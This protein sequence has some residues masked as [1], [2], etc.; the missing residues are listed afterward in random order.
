MTPRLRRR[1]LWGLVVL[2]AFIPTACRRLGPTDPSP[3]DVTL[4]VVSGAGQF[5]PPSE[6]LIDSLAVSVRAEDGDLPVEGIL[7]EWEI[8]AGPVGAQLTPQ[9]SQSDSAGLARARLRLGSDLGQYLI[10]ASIRDRPE[11]SVEFEAWAV[12]PPTLDAVSP[13]TVNTGEIITLSGT[14]FSA[15]A[16]HNVVLF[17]GIAGAVITAD[18]ARL[19]VRVPLCLPT[20]SVDVS[21]QLGGE[22]ST[23]L[24][25]SVTATASFLE[26]AL[27]A[28]TTLS[29]QGV[30]ACVRL[31]SGSPQ[32]YLAVVQ[33]T[34]TIGAARFDYTVTGL[35]P[36][37]PVTVASRSHRAF[38]RRTSDR[39]PSRAVTRRDF[40]ALGSDTVSGAWSLNEAQA[41]W[42]LFLREKEGLLW[43]RVG[44]LR[45]AGISGGQ[46]ARSFPGAV[47]GIG[48]LGEFEVLRADGK[49]DQVTA[50]V[51]L[52]SERAILYEDT[53]AQGSLSQEDVELFS[54]L[55]DDPIYPVDTATFG[56]P[57]DLDGNGRVII[58]F[59]PTVNRLSPPG[60]NDFVGG[61]FFGLDLMPELEHSNGR[62]V[63]YV[64][65]PDP[66]GEFG[67]VREADLLRSFVP[68]ILAHEFQHM[69]HYNQRMI[70]REAS[71]SEAV[72]LSEGL[73]HMAEDLVGEELRRRGRVSEAD[74]YQRGNR[75]RAS[76]FLTEPSDVSLIIAAGPGNLEERGAAWLFLEYLRGQAGGD[77]VLASLTGTALTGTVNV[78]TVMGR[79]WAD[80][81]S[82]WSAA[83]ELE[84]Q[85]F[86]RGALPLRDELRFLGFDLM[87]ALELGGDGFPS[88][89]TVHD[90]GDFSDQGRLWSASG[91]YFLIGTSEGGVALGLAGSNG[92]PASRNS[93]LR[94]KLIRVF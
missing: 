30:P 80:L 51:R 94:L 24:P 84:R 54:G 16:A 2:V 83:L 14:N 9:T 93:A 39:L 79:D 10:R 45:G 4:T 32:E 25:L 27:G 72:W 44:P 31:G 49:F 77:S 41:E 74:E 33:S 43:E 3:T 47:P 35:R 81:F 67:N 19:D 20:R 55:F 48:D 86:E 22:A 68:P 12:L 13:G 57:S 78:Q 59:T 8:T 61:F 42:D 11:E 91:A 71:N 26:L 29:G 36:A 60:S 28:D 65:V 15:I 58:L 87:E 62:E 73:A 56:S 23:S 76:L 89:L 38:R 34:A 53:T 75:T 88:T 85:I 6:F 18:T 63:F 46:A 90:S 66:T 64:L 37:A 82:D 70:E 52:V 50:T 5:G 21:V 17:S 40:G 7:V 92:G 1:V 69:I